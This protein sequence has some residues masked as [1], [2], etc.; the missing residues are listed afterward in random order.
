M[1]IRDNILYGEEMD[2]AHYY[3]TIKLCELERDF[4]ILPAGDLTEIGERGINLSGGQKAR[5]GLARAVYSR[6][7][8]YLMDDPIS[9]L[10]AEV[11]KNIFK[12]VIFGHL[13][14]KTCVL[15]TH[16]IDFLS[17]AHKVVVME[18]G[19]IITQGTYDEVKDHKVVQKLL[20]VNDLN[21]NKVTE[22]KMKLNKEGEVVECEESDQE[23]D[24]SSEPEEEQK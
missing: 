18:K 22:K 1:T 23:Y 6:K 19:R 7:D 14:G 2:Q 16:A 12:N 4:E 11:R 17:Y 8:I 20:E 13:K 3:D 5:I 9:A 10:D 15:V 21:K 24:S